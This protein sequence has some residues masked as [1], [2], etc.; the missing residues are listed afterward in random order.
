MR[1]LCN[2]IYNQTKEKSEIKLDDYPSNVLEA[3]IEE[4]DKKGIYPILIIERFHAF[5]RIADDHLLSVL[6]ALRT[7]ENNKMITT[8]AL[9]PI[10]YDTIRRRMPPDLPFVNSVYGDNHDVAI[11]TPLPRSDFINAAISR[12]L[13]S[14]TA[15]KLYN[16]GGGPDAVYRALI[17][18]ACESVSDI[19]EGCLMRLRE[20]IIRFFEYSLGERS[21]D[22]D[23]LLRRLALG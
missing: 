21:Y 8:I 22:R 23:E 14:A 12:G 15:H 2:E 20:T 3:L 1:K 17:D 5:V 6:S 7:H 16:I 11:M 18:V 9:S 4:A 19:I 10:D 13:S